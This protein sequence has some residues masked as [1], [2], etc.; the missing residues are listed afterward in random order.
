[1][2]APNITSPTIS[3]DAAVYKTLEI[4]YRNQTN[5]SNARLYW[6]NEGE[7]FSES[8]A[9]SFMT[10]S[11]GDIHTYQV[12]LAQLDNWSGTVVQIRLDPTTGGD[13]NFAIDSLRFSETRKRCGRIMGMLLKDLRQDL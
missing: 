11:D 5:N 4:T 13:G 10:D 8:K 9:V 1:M 6:R 3:I 7:G 12:N 2:E